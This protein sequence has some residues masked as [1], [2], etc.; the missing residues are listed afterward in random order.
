MPNIKALS[1]PILKMG[2]L[3][4]YVPTCDPQGGAS[5]DPWRIIWIPLVEVHKDMRYTKYESSMPSSFT[6]EEFW[7]SASLFLCSKLW[8]PGSGPVLTPGASYEQTW[9]RSTRRC[10]I[11]I[12]KAL[13][14]PVSKKNFEIFYLCSCVPTCDPRDVASFDHW[15]IITFSLKVSAPM[16]IF[17]LVFANTFRPAIHLGYLEKIRFYPHLFER[18]YATKFPMTANKMGMDR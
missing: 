15:G 7:R 8:P 17:W 18:L 16:L 5:F 12:I 13:G 1:L 4:S 6:E 3:G 2:F 10:Y 9:W 14:L 11:P